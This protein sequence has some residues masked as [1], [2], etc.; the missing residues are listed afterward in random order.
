VANS[1]L[2]KTAIFGENPNFGR[3]VSALGASGI[4]VKEEAVKIKVSPLHKKEIDVAVSIGRG[5]GT[6]VVYTSDLT[7]EYIRINA[8]YN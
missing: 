4:A 6:A 3:I 7:P 5:K 1:A 2:F 8:E